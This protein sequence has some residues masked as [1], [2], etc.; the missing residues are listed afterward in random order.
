MEPETVI[1]RHLQSPAV[2]KTH[3]YVSPREDDEG[4]F[5]LFSVNDL[6]FSNLRGAQRQLDRIR[7]EA[8][9]AYAADNGI[10]PV[11]GAAYDDVLFLLEMFSACAIPMPEIGWAEDGSLGLEWRLD[12]GIATMGLYG[13]NLVIYTAFFGEKRQVEGVCTLS[14]MAMLMGYLIMLFPPLEPV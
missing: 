9:G 13:D 1:R 4:M 11:P 7:Q 5:D 8:D 2:P 3:E 12:G 10:D 14:D 6:N